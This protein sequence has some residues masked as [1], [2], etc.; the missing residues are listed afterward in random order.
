MKKLK[1]II[2]AMMLIFV[3]YGCADEGNTKPSG[4]SFMGGT[5]GIDARFE[6][7]GIL[8]PQGEYVWVG[9]KFPIE[10]TI[11]NV[12]EELIPEKELNITIVGVDSTQFGFNP[13]GHN[14]REILPKS[15]YNPSGGMET[16]MIT[17]GAS[18]DSL[19]SP[20]FTATFNARIE[21]P[22]KTKIAVPNVCFKGDFRDTSLC[23]HVGPRTFSYS[24]APV[25]VTAVTQ[26]PSGSNS[27]SLKFDIENRGPGNAAAYGEEFN[28]N[29]DTVN[30]ELIEGNEEGD[31]Q[32][33]CTSM[34]NPDYARLTNKR[35]SIICRSGD[36]DSN[37][38]YEKQLTL[39]L[40]YNYRESI[41]KS[42]I[43]RNEPN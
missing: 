3:L 25:I 30:F 41:Q 23:N 22:Y 21:Y 37:I 26:E 7:M 6:Q 39:E 5:R 15:Q 12:G 38:L 24:G 4:A 40:S 1:G 42:L 8:D 31:I 35:G 17:S 16:I 32:W 33:E 20:Q 11:Y 10:V 13:N 14:T 28:P 43:I 2:I 9:D 34:G 29:R 18:L 19:T 27:I 36:I